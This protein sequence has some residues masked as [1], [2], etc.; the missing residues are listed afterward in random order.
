MA[1]LAALQNGAFG[2][3][4][5]STSKAVIKKADTAK[6]VIKVQSKVQLEQELEVL[7]KKQL[8]LMVKVAV[9]QRVERK[10]EQDLA[11]ERVNQLD[12]KEGVGEQVKRLQVLNGDIKKCLATNKADMTS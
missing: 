2:N 3:I 7:Q 5:G 8:E 9:N 1:Q 6:E 11:K 10:I 12:L 4:T